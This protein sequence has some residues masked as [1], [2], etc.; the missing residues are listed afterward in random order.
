MDVNATYNMVG[1]NTLADGDVFVTRH[2]QR[3]KYCIKTFDTYQPGGA[4]NT[5]FTILGTAGGG[6]HHFDFEVQ[7]RNLHEEMVLAISGCGLTLPTNADAY[8]IQQGF[9]PDQG[10]VFVF[11]GH[12]HLCVRGEDAGTMWLLD[13]ASGELINQ[14]LNNIMVVVRRWTL[15][16]PRE[17][18]TDSLLAFHP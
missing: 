13:L 3:M 12:P 16:R 14:P 8:A 11:D 1:F 4:K 7:F 2:D 5:H 18:K 6:D 17:P 10:T 15:E 9:N